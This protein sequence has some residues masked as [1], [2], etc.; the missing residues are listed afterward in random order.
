MSKNKKPAPKKTKKKVA[1]KSSKKKKSS[2]E[3]LIDAMLQPLPGETSEA[4]KIREDLIKQ[5]RD[6]DKPKPRGLVSGGGRW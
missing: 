6:A 1:K 5:T 3:A 2:G 4:K